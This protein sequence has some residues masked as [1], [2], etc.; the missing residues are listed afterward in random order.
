MFHCKDAE[1]QETKAAA[2]LEGVCLAAQW[3]EIPI[4]LEADCLAVKVVQK[5]K[6]ICHDRSMVMP[7]IQEMLPEG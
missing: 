1:D 6:A 4:T 5:L 2:S 7:L 3:P